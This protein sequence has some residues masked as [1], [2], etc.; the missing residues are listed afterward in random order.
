MFY[1]LPAEVLG[2]PLDPAF[3]LRVRRKLKMS[4]DAKKINNL[5]HAQGASCQARLFEQ[6]FYG[7]FEHMTIAFESTSL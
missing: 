6:K 3:V 2:A 7:L 4:V 5:L 1:E